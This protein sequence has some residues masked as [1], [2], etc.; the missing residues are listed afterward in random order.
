MGRF[1]HSKKAH[2][3]GKGKKKNKFT[4]NKK[5]NK[6]LDAS[7]SSTSSSFLDSTPK[8]GITQE[9]QPNLQQT[10]PIAVAV[11]YLSDTEMQRDEVL[12]QP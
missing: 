5:G 11:A 7:C 8:K 2:S 12:T 9:I 10:I 1:H 3:E 6:K 4:I